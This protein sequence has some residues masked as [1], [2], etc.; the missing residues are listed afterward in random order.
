MRFK[1]DISNITTFTKLV[2]CLNSTSKVAWLKLD[3]EQ[4]HF[5][6]MEEATVKETLFSTYRIASASSNT[7]N[8]EV[9][10]P[11]LLRA[12]RSCASSP[13]ATLRLTKRAADNVPILC[14]T[15]ST[16]SS[17][18]TLVTQEIPVRVLAPAAVA[19]LGEP[20]VP[21]PQVS[22]V[23][24][25][26]AAVRGVVERMNRLDV[27][28]VRLEARRVGAEREFRMG[29][30]GE[31]VKVESVWRGLGTGLGVEEEEEEEMEEGEGWAG[32]TVNGREWAKVLKCVGLAKSVV[33]FFVNDFA[34]V[35][36]VYL[37]ENESDAVITYYMSSL[38][39]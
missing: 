38:S 11:I 5:T 14:I 19:G 36:Y 35:V 15:V 34:L 30:E 13:A 4:V 3:E 22:V 24:P 7:I 17:S 33:A 23:L 25:G 37:T 8:L 31:E 1:T 32:V 6:L 29:V 20:E 18:S 39:D 2:S 16:S 9:P 21:P 28:R 10:L 12:L 27:R 26:L